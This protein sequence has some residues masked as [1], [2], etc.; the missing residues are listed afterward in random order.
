[1]PDH[2]D[3]AGLIFFVLRCA[4][5]T[6]DEARDALI[7]LFGVHYAGPFPDLQVGKERRR[8]LS[9]CARLWLCPARAEKSIRVKQHQVLSLGPTKTGRR[10]VGTNFDRLGVKI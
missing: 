6:C 4:A 9:Y 1:M 2:C 10:F 5:D 3:P 7:D 8:E